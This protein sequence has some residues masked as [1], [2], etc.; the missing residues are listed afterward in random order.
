[1]SHT[2]HR[3]RYFELVSSIFSQP[4][5]WPFAA[6]FLAACALP[7]GDPASYDWADFDLCYVGPAKP[8]STCTLTDEVLPGSTT[9][10]GSF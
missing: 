10:F 8:Y 7:T 2:A 9:A 3:A 1:M 4:S 6:D 5:L